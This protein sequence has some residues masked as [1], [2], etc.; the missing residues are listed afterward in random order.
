MDAARR[1]PRADEARTPYSPESDH[2][3]FALF[4][5]VARRLRTVCAGM[6]P[7]DFDAL[8]RGICLI[9][10]RWAARDDDTAG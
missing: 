10:L 9:K 4:E 3:F 1:S 6:P 8:V 5:D 2:Q 7:K